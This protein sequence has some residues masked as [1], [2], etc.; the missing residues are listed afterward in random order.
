[1]ETACM[2]KLYAHVISR[3]LHKQWLLQ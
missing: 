1:M 3:Q 2:F